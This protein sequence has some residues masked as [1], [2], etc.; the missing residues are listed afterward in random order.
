MSTQLGSTRFDVSEGGGHLISL[1]TSLQFALSQP[2]GLEP[3]W[4][5]ALDVTRHS[6]SHQLRARS[7]S[8]VF[9]TSSEERPLRF[10]G[11]EDIALGHE[12]IVLVDVGS[13]AEDG[14]VGERDLLQA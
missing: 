7:P 4:L 13:Q 2:V 10:F 8:V 1:Y 14:L 11:E 12:V 3:A 6:L 9:S 5:L